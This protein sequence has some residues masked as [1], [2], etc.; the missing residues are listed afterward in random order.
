[1]SD[2]GRIRVAIAGAGGMG[3]EA[4]AW[5][6][7]ARPDSEPVA[8]FTA[9]A[10][11]RPAG[12]DIGLP[13][14]DDLQALRELR[15]SVVVLGVGDNG[16]RMTLA[17]EAEASGLE[18]LTVVHPTAFLGPG[19]AL[20]PGSLV[21]PG[22][23]ITRDVRIGRAV[24]VNYSASIGHDGTIGDGAF[25]GPGAVL[26]G[27]V[28]VAAGAMVGAGAVILPGRMVG[29]GA[30]IAAGAVVTR[31]V[32]PAAVVSGVPAQPMGIG[33]SDAR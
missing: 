10:S 21:A 2:V 3:R 13:V 6:R 22:C 27:D 20:G 19:V 29:A 24:I 5:L 17:E 11:E 15:A 26:T 33:G 12:A 8:F 7:D 4:L 9:D 1:M 31:D 28:Q 14:V 25:I 16:R 18:L 32:P 30:V 23:V